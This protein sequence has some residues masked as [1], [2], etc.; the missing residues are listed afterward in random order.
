MQGAHNSARPAYASQRFAA[1]HEA[2]RL[3]QER[4]EAAFMAAEQ[5]FRRAGELAEQMEHT[6][7]AAEMA[8]DVYPHGAPKGVL[9]R[10]LEDGADAESVPAVGYGCTCT[11]PKHLLRTL[12]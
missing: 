12:R 2:E 5:R 9:R 4:E 6:V 8:A 3:Q 11:A 7:S 1:R 10:L